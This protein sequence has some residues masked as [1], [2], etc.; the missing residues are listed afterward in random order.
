M[1]ASIPFASL[2][3]LCL[4]VG[5][6]DDTGVGAQETTTYPTTTPP[7]QDPLL[8]EPTIE[9]TDPTL[10]ERA[11]ELGAETGALLA[12]TY[13]RGIEEADSMLTDLRERLAPELEQATDATRE[14]WKAIEEDLEES[15]QDAANKLEKLRNA[16]QERLEE[17]KQSYLAAYERLK[18]Q[19]AEARKQLD[20]N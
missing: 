19:I 5:C 18:A 15:R 14:R 9:G 1:N 20:Q 13:R 2:A 16:S 8:Q 6:R 17:A 12:D 10:G 7:T 3:A 4:F 11:R